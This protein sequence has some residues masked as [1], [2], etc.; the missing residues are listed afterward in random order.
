[1]VEEDVQNALSKYKNRD[2]W[3]KWGMDSLREQGTAVLLEGPPGCGKTSIAKWIAHQVGKGFKQLDMSALQS[4]GTPGSTEKKVDEF[5][6]DCKRRQNCTIFMDECEAVLIS[7]DSI[8]DAGL[9]WQ[10]GTVNKI[11][12]RMNMYK[13]LILAASNHPKMIDS[14]LSDRFIAIIKVERP[15]EPA[16]KRLWKQ[17]IPK[18]FPL[19]SSPDNLSKLGRFDLS[20]RQIETVILNCASNALRLGKAPTLQMMEVC[21]QREI[22]KHL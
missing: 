6:E 10:L 18:N 20:G 2:L 9:T 5:F 16:R 17:K 21:C 7:R 11:I 14:A 4:D 15:D 3:H 1:M 19:T 13:G 8:G 22:K 12:T